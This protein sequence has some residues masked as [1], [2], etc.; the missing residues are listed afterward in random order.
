M[1]LA[2]GDVRDSHVDYLL[3]RLWINP[4]EFVGAAT[5]TFGGPSTLTG[6]F[7]GGNAAIL[8]E[9]AQQ[10]ISAMRFSSTGATIT[11]VFRPSDV[12][13]RWPVYIRP[14]W[15]TNAAVASVATFNC[16]FG[17]IAAGFAPATPSTA[18]SVALVS[19]AKVAAATAPAWTRWGMVAPLSTGNFAGQ[20]FPAT[21]DAVAFSLSVSTLSLAALSSDFVWVYGVEIMY[22][23]RQTYGGG[24]TREARY[25]GQVLGASELEAGPTGAAR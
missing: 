12:D 14:L 16:F 7:G 11:T 6:A 9:V 25:V 3:K 10:R 23:P 13:N 4:I 5:A 20:T 8:T 18:L 19:D 24:S 17:H 15:S 2:L 21:V 1:G 22:T